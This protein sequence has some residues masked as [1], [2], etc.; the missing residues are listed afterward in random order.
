M[1]ETHKCDRCGGEFET[2]GGMARHKSW[3][4]YNPWDDERVLRTL[5][6]DELMSMQQIADELDCSS[7]TVERR[8]KEFDLDRRKAPDDPTRPPCH[9]FNP[10]SE[11]VGAVYEK[12]YC[13]I[14]GE[15]YQAQ[16]HR[17]IAV[18]HGLLDPE[19]FFDNS[20]LIHHKTEHGLDNRPDNLERMDRGDHIRH[21]EIWKGSD[22]ID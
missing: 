13:R 9:T 2:A 22:C 17:L 14:D 6:Y 20:V 1:S 10:Y 8:M 7:D 16:I 4:H 3:T 11:E 15:L 12:A 5:Y 21:H 19:E 18:G